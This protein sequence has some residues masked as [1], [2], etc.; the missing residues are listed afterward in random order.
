MGHAYDF[1]TAGEQ[2]GV[3]AGSCS[4]AMSTNFTFERFASSPA[5]TLQPRQ[6]TDVSMFSPV[7]IIGFTRAMVATR[8]SAGT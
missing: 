8:R 3:L 2:L 6:N 5:T 7:M 1:E 4:A